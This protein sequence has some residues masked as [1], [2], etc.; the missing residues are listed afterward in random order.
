MARRKAGDPGPE[1]A[2]GAAAADGKPD[3]D[4]LE[5]RR[6]ARSG[7]SVTERVANGEP[8]EPE[9][10]MFPQGSLDGDSKVTLKTLIKSGSDVTKKASMGTAAVPIKGTGFFDPEEEVSLLVR[11]L[12]GGIVPVPT[13]EKTDGSRHKVKSWNLTQ[14]LTPIH[15]Q[16]AGTMYTREQVVEMLDEAGVASAVVS[17]LLGEEPKA[18]QG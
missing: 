18:A 10:E 6:Q 17:R 1:R 11:V 5:R 14:Q 2:E 7:S 12:P 15:V 13:H 16:D 3:D 4:E 8:D 9:P